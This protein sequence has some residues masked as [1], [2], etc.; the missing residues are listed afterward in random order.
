LI[1]VIKHSIHKIQT[2]QSIQQKL[3][4]VLLILVALAAA[5]PQLSWYLYP[6]F[7]LF[8]TLFFAPFILF[9]PDNTQ[10]SVRFGLVSLLC[11][12]FYPVLKIQS[13]FFLGLCFLCFFII[14]SLWGKLN[15]ASI[16]WVALLSPMSAYVFKIF[17]F[18]IRLKLTE[19][20]AQLFQFLNVEVVANG[21]NEKRSNIKLRFLSYPV[22]LIFTCFLVV[23]ANLIRIISLI[24]FQSKEGTLGHEIIGIACL[25][26]YV[27]VPLYFIIPYL[28]DRFEIL[29]SK[30][31]LTFK[32]PKNTYI[33]QSILLVCIFGFLFYFNITGNFYQHPTYE[34]TPKLHYIKGFKSKP[35]DFGGTKLTNDKALIYHKPC[36]NF[37]SADHNPSI[38]WKGSGYVFKTEQVKLINGIEIYTAGLVKD[39]DEKLFTAWWFTNGETITNNQLNWRWQMISGAPDFAMINV[40]C[41]SEAELEKQVAELLT[42]SKLK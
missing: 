30:K 21:N 19:W 8:L 3:W 27:V 36:S 37:W 17:G 22:F 20:A 6:D 23:V 29:Q 11:F 34:K 2:K 33:N 14:E 40:T 13:C 1:S 25:I 35:V 18:P 10:K 9:I 31:Q 16:F 28:V 12:A 4:I 42:I 24:L 26:F 7:S 15:N 32:F 41:N 39:K 38:C 5:L